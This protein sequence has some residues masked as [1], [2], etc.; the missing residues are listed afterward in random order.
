MRT[1][2]EKLLDKLGGGLLITGVMLNSRSYVDSRSPTFMH[3][4]V[5]M[6]VY[7]DADLHVRRKRIH[8]DNVMSQ[9]RMKK[10]WH[11]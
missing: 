11:K 4:E 9:P 2:T 1:P 3:N 8:A 7:D 6:Y 10:A 5:R